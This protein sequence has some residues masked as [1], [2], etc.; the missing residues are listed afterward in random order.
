[1]LKLFPTLAISLA[2]IANP[3]YA[4]HNRGR[5]DRDHQSHSQHN[6]HYDNHNDK[7]HDNGSAWAGVALIGAIAGLAL[8]ADNNEPKQPVYVEP[9]YP[10]YSP[11]QPGGNVWYYCQSSGIYYPYTRACPEGWQAVPAGGY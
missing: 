10:Q 4:D 2:L 7:H 8:L 3:V 6:R 11:P 5:D 1:M 9:A